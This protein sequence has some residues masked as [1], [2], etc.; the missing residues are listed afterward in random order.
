MTPTLEAVRGRWA[1][2]LEYFGIDSSY[3]RNRH[4][5]CPLCGGR[6]RFRF[7]DKEGRGTYYCNQCGPG[8]GMCL[9]RKHMGWNFVTACNEIDAIIGIVAAQPPR[10]STKMADRLERLKRMLA[11]AQTPRL[12]FDYLA[13]RGLS[14]TSPVLQGHRGLWHKETDQHIPAVI[15][16]VHDVG[17][18]LRSVAR[19]FLADVEPRKKLMPPVGTARGCAV[20]LYDA[21]PVMAVTEGVETGIACRQL[22][23]L[24]VWAA[25]SAHGL[26]TFEPPAICE[27]LRIFADNDANG[28]GQCAAYNLVQRLTRI[29]VFTEVVIPPVRGTDWLDVLNNKGGST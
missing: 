12:V 17:G 20:Q 23:G 4:G 5:P 25:L 15:A 13:S 11:Q 26:E 24:P 18:N 22:F 27:V 6:D 29:G 3:L 21:A 10:P 16:P 28:V 1:G 2:I 9:L 19:I 14:I 8:D 7:D